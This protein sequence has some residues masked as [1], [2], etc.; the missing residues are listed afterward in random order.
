MT[1]PVKLNVRA[2]VRLTVEV[3]VESACISGAPIEQLYD[4]ALEDVRVLLNKKLGDE[5]DTYKIIGDPIV[6][7][8]AVEMRP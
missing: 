4:K 5:G 8:L 2:V 3:P 6:A 7:A 1:T